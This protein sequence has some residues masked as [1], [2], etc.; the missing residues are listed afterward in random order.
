M[1]QALCSGCDLTLPCCCFRDTLKRQYNLGQYYLEVNLEDLAS[2]DEALADKMYKQPAEHLAV[3]SHRLH[4]MICVVLLLHDVKVFAHLFSFQ[5]EE[6]AKEVADEITAPRPKG[7]ENVHDIQILLSSDANCSSLRDM[8]VSH[9][10]Y[11]VSF[12]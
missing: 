4:D 1:V 8:K 3:V 10:I 11:C 2:F 6:A 7:E 5:F 9:L 12:T